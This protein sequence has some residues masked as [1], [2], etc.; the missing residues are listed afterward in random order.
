ME[1][2]GAVVI[3]KHLTSVGKQGLDMFPYP[4]S[5]ITDDAEAHLLF[6]NYTGLFHLLE[7]LTKLLLILYLMPTEHMDDA[8]AIQQREA[9]ALR[10]APLP[11]PPCP[12]G[13]LAPAPRAGLP[14]AVGTGRYI[15][16]SM[17]NTKTGRRKRPADPAAMRRSISWRDGVTSNPV[18]PSATWLVT[19][20]IRSLPQ[21]SPVR[22]PKSDWAVSYGTA[23]T[24]CAAAYCISSC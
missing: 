18:S 15:G 20:G 7:G 16:P 10:V 22:S 9:K 3:I 14:G 21:C 12:P 24:N 11:P 6:W 5:P 2:L 13:P 1:V 8:L 17:P 23:V 4:L 19:V